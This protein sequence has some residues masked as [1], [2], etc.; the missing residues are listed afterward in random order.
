MRVADAVRLHSL[1][2]RPELNGR[3][4]TIVK[5]AGPGE[6]RLGVRLDGETAAIAL[7]AANLTN[8]TT[9][10]IATVFT[11][12]DLLRNV[13]TFIARYARAAILCRVSKQWDDVVWKH[14]DLFRSVV[15]CCGPMPTVRLWGRKITRGFHRSPKLGSVHFIEEGALPLMPHMLRHCIPNLALVEKLFVEPVG[16]NTDEDVAEQVAAVL[17]VEF[18]CLTTLF[19]ANLGGFCWDAKGD[20][21]R[22][23]ATQA[24]EWVRRHLH[25]LQ[26]F[27]IDGD[28]V[29]NFYDDDNGRQDMW[30]FDAAEQPGLT[31]L[32]LDNAFGASSRPE[33]DVVKRWT[34]SVRE[35]VRALDLCHYPALSDVVEMIALLPGLRRLRW[36]AGG[37]LA[38]DFELL[39]RVLTGSQ[40]EALYLELDSSED[41]PIGTFDDFMAVRTLKEFA[42][43]CDSCTWA[44]DKDEKC[45][46]EHLYSAFCVRAWE[47]SG[48]ATSDPGVAVFVCDV[49]ATA[50]CLDPL[51]RMLLP[52]TEEEWHLDSDARGLET[53]PFLGWQAVDTIQVTSKAARMLHAERHLPA[54]AALGASAPAATERPLADDIMSLFAQLQTHSPEHT[55]VVHEGQGASTIEGQD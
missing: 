52:N 12:E 24:S 54:S 46:T 42:V 36:V 19:L 16:D 49:T 13:L 29:V 47:E 15:V 3:R 50:D 7:K 11:N 40:I 4:G 5:A 14:G 38:E 22:A 17:A 45:V 9:A 21:G 18:P 26:H 51:H 44:G 2:A 1:Q 41:L 25:S 30:V 6:V 34:S 55:M 23:R 39:A 31:S 33:L 37:C 32:Q 43:K 8:L 35:K 53:L 28:S 20:L 10:A 48:G 27:H